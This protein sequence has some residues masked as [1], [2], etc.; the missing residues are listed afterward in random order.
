MTYGIAAT[1]HSYNV[2][3]SIVLM[4]YLTAA[5]SVPN[6]TAASM[7]FALYLFEPPE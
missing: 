1:Y 4:Q 5:P 3:M 2:H 7:C 6:I